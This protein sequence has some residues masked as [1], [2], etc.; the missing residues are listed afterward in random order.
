MVTTLGA[1]TTVCQ[2]L[3]KSRQSVTQSI[4]LSFR[5][6]GPGFLV[7]VVWRS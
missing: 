6:A 4:R 7:R 2:Y 5:G 3:V 1:P